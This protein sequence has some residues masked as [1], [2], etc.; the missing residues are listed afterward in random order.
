MSKTE[1]FLGR[2]LNESGRGGFSHRSA[3]V[4]QWRRE[5]Q[6]LG[7]ASAHIVSLAMTLFYAYFGGS[8]HPETAMGRG[9]L[10]DMLWG[11]AS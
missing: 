6:I 1:L 2:S 4:R 7:I 9:T 11:P 8:V 10:V 5:Q 3:A